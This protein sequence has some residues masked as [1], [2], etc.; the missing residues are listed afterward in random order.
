MAPLFPL[1]GSSASLA[2]SDL[3]GQRGNWRFGSSGEKRPPRTVQ[4]LRE[5]PPS[6]VVAMVTATSSITRGWDTVWE[7]WVTVWK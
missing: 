6:H 7:R 3:I 4:V 1:W 5:G 2:G